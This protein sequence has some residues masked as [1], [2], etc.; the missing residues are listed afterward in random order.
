M[1]KMFQTENGFHTDIDSD[2]A[3]IE[4][5]DCNFCHVLH[6]LR[7]FGLCPDQDLS[8]PLITH[9]YSRIFQHKRINTF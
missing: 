6:R 4:S 2:K 7:G 8:R 3:K 9:C 1:N 5:N